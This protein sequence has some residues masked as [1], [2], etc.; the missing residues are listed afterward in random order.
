MILRATLY[1]TARCNN[2]WYCA[3]HNNVKGQP[4]KSRVP[5]WN[6]PGCQSETIQDAKLKQ[7]IVSKWNNSKCQSVK[8]NQVKAKQFKMLKWANSK[9]QSETIQSVKSTNKSKLG[10]GWCTTKASTPQLS[11][12]YTILWIKTGPNSSDL[13]YFINCLS[14]CQE[15]N[16]EN[17]H[18]L[19]NWINSTKKWGV[20]SNNQEWE[21]QTIK[22]Q[23]I[24]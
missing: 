9:C 16:F 22:W 5:K 13:I 21:I 15:S 12:K 19:G 20:Q 23:K 24:N 2:L 11:K 7:F 6:N 8:V 17:Q 4:R 14:K 18:C 3:L 1:D 10:G